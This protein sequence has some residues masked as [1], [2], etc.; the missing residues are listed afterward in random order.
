MG[1]AAWGRYV[2]RADRA[3]GCNGL[4]METDGTDRR[5]VLPHPASPVRA[6]SDA[7]RVRY[8]GTS[9]ARAPV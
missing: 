9:M 3:S 2:M 7:V 5:E 4:Q 8:Y 1:L 6:M